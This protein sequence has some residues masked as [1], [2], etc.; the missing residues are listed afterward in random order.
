MPTV[1]CSPR[2]AA[3]A[4]AR[5]ASARSPPAS[6]TAWYALTAGPSASTI[7]LS[8]SVAAPNCW[9]PARAACKAAPSW[10]ADTSVSSPR[11]L[12]ACRNPAP[13]SGPDAPPVLLIRARPTVASTTPGVAGFDSSSIVSAAWKPRRRLMPWSASPIAA[14][15]WVRWSALSTTSWAA[16]AIQA[17]N[18]LASIIIL[19]V[20]STGGCTA[21]AGSA[22][23]TQRRGLDRSVPEFGELWGKSTHRDRATGHLQTGDV[24]ADQAARDRHAM[25]GKP[26]RNGR[27][28]HV[29]LDERGTTEAVDHHQH[30]AGQ[31]HVGVEGVQ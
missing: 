21:A 11:V 18:T 27:E 5:V 26:F 15:R 4:A 31:R 28:H 8:P 2:A 16:S 10:T 30:V 3:S 13:Y 25:A 14:S 24:V 6:M 20:S 9:M 22:P 23:P 29:Q 12:A 19:L 17:R 7:V 1:A